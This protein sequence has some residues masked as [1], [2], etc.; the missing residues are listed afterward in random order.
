[1]LAWSVGSVT[2][3]VSTV[4]VTASVSDHSLLPVLNW[5]AQTIVLPLLKI[6]S[7]LGIPSASYRAIS[8]GGE[9]INGEWMV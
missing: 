8:K 1:M 9:M 4:L 2:S 3:K 7:V 5:Y 6:T